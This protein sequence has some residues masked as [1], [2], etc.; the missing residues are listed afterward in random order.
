[1]SIWTPVIKAFQFEHQTAWCYPEDK[2]D[3]VEKTH[4]IRKPG[5]RETRMENGWLTIIP[6]PFGFTINVSAF[7]GENQYSFM[8]VGGHSLQAHAVCHQTDNQIKSVTGDYVPMPTAAKDGTE[9]VEM[10]WYAWM[11]DGL[12]KKVKELIDEFNKENDDG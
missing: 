12:R 5:F 11:P 3:E 2:R 10:Q 8:V 7:D 9:D 6:Q 4:P 1:M